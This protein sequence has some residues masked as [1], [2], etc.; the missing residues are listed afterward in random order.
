MEPQPRTAASSEAPTNRRW[1]L[2]F[3]VHSKFLVGIRT[4]V[5]V[6]GLSLA[7]APQPPAALLPSLSQALRSRTDLWG[8]AALRQTN[9]P[10]YEF[11]E[12]LLPPLRYVN[13]DFRSYPLVLSSP[14]A[15]VKARLIS[16]GS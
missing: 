3:E 9:G 16:N 15:G 2:S 7:S 10:S 14:N 1:T 11:F 8:E 6:A 13:A 4:L 12:K 5:F